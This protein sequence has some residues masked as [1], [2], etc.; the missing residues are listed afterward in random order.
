MRAAL[1]FL[2]VSLF[3]AGCSTAP[4]IQHYP[5]QA[6]P[7]KQQYPH[8]KGMKIQSYAA[9]LLGIPYKYGGITPRTG[10][11]CSGLTMYVH[12]QNG[13]TIPRVARDQF[14]QGKLIARQALRSGDLVFFETYRKGASH[15]GI[16]IGDNQFIHS[17]NKN[18]NVRISNLSNSYYRQ[19]Y[20]GARRY[21]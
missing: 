6:G 13:I 2:I 9:S 4:K 10:F 1:L 14:K 21:W 12:K 15:V 18:K 16:Y 19:R 8:S 17:P 20:L 11:D 7:S 5:K 3:L